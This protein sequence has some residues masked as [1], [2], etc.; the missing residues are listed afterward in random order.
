MWFKKWFLLGGDWSL[1]G[2]IQTKKV[3]LQEKSL[4]L[5]HHPHHFV[6]RPFYCQ[7]GSRYL[8]LLC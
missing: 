4:K 1:L 8:L 7:G 2:V 3:N 6:E 5:L